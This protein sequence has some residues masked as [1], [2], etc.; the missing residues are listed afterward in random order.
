[1]ASAASGL[2]SHPI[3]D[4][5]AS[6]G[7]RSHNR[8]VFGYGV[9]QAPRVGFTTSTMRLGQR[10]S[11]AACLK[12]TQC[13]D[14]ALLQNQISVRL[15]SDDIRSA[16]SSHAFFGKPILYSTKTEPAGTRRFQ[17]PNTYLYLRAG[18]PHWMFS[19]AEA[20]VHLGH[21]KFGIGLRMA[22]AA[23][24]SS[25]RHSHATIVENV[26]GSHGRYERRDAYD[27]PRLKTQN[28]PSTR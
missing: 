25:T 20:F 5:S 16:S 10:S 3:L 2:L 19:N 23:S 6:P 18:L 24:H 13:P 8:K 14:F 15:G 27:N 26:F 7:L 4:P 1:M 12:E 9:R 17:T 21:K 28:K 22:R 11:A